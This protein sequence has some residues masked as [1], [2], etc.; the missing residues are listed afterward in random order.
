[1]SWQHQFL[2]NSLGDYALAAAAMLAGFVFMRFV[3]RRISG[4]IFK[5]ISKTPNQAHKSWLQEKLGA[6]LQ[7]LVMLL[8]GY[9]AISHLEVPPHWGLKSASEFGIAMVAQRSYLLALIVVVVWT[10]LRLVGYAAMLLSEKAAAT[11]SRQDDQLIPFVSEILKIVVITLGVFV[12]LAVVFKIDIAALIAGLGI[13]GLALALAAKE[14]LENLLAS[15][16]IFFD[17]PFAIGDFVRVNGQTG[18]VEKIGFRSTRIRTVEKTYLTIPNLQ[19]V[20]NVLDNLSMRSVQRVKFHFVV[21]FETEPETLKKF[22]E[23][24]RAALTNQ[25]R[26]VGDFEVRFSDFTL[27]GYEVL[28]LYFIDSIDY[29]SFVEVREKIHFEIVNI[30]RLFKVQFAVQAPPTLNPKP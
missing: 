16:M 2:N 30:A 6:P 27:G 4:V 20:N 21:P 7:W 9:L 11:E 3:A 19:M 29:K 24:V 1:M 8:V 28:V 10:G 15:F 23:S 17:K 18:T 14:S 5:L 13:G 22:L 12:A 26:V 25:P